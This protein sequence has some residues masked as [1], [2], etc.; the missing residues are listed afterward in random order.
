MLKGLLQQGTEIS[1]YARVDFDERY[2]LKLIIEDLD[3]SYTIGKMELKRQETLETLLKQGLLNR[4]N[5]I[6]LVPV[7]QRIAVLSSPHAAGLQDYLDQLANNPYGYQFFNQLFPTAMQGVRVE[8]EILKQ[9]K[10]IA[11]LKEN[12]DAIIIIRGGGSKLDLAAFDSFELGKAVARCPLPVF[13]GIGHEID[14]T[15]LDRVAHTALK[16]P[17]AVADYLLNRML[18][19]ESIISEYG[20]YIKNVSR[21]L[22]QEEKAQLLYCQKMLQL[23]VE[24]GLK[25]ENLEIDQLK[26][27]LPLAISNHLKHKRNQLDQLGKIC[28][29]LTPETALARGFSLTSVN[30]K[31]ITDAAAIKTGAILKTQLRQGII[32]SRVIK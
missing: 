18:Q 31:I 30:G 5:Q 25:K 28:Q 11:R 1:F 15:I 3:P 29:L 32:K 12:F 13:T 23:Q 4:N 27:R 10:K 8:A 19:F 2:G 14:E 26:Q 9:L 20:H 24:N 7:L 21:Q 22:M 6:A 17:T 16:T